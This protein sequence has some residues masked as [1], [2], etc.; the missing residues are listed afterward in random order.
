MVGSAASAVAEGLH[1]SGQYLQEHG[2]SEMTEDLASLIRTYPKS[3][4]GVAFALG[5]LYGSS[6]MHRPE[7][8]RARVER[9]A[10]RANS[11]GARYVP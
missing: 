8:R 9:S 1:T 2:L 3:S 4:L 11:L 7:E 10:W 5:L 6:P